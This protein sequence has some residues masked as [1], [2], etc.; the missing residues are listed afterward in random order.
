MLTK[1][2]NNTLNDFYQEID[3]SINNSEENFDIDIS[4]S[5]KSIYVKIE[6]ARSGR[7]NKNFCMYTPRAMDQGVHSFI[8][9]FN[10]H[11]Q[12]KHNGEA[13]G[14]IREAEHVREFFPNASKDFLKIVSDVNKYSEQS[15]G[16]NLVLAIKRLI[17]T[18]EY[19]SGEYRGL[20]I[21][22]IYGD[23][24]DS[25][26]IHELKVQD[27]SRGKVSIGG[28]SKEVYCSVCTSKVTKRHKHKKGN[29]YNNELCFYINNDLYLDH[30]GFVTTPADT[31]TSTEIVQDDEYDG[32]EVDIINY[33]L[34]NSVEN[35]M[36]LDDLKTKA[37][38]LDAVKKII[39][40]SFKDEADAELA[41][42]I[43]EGNLKSSRST[44]YLLATDSILNLRGPVGIHIA[45]NLLAELDD[46][47]ENKPYLKEVLQ[48]A[49]DLL[50]IEN[51]DEALKE[52]L[53][54]KKED[55]SKDKVKTPVEEV[56]SDKED[57]K[58]PT[59][60]DTSKDQKVE[61]QEDNALLKAFSDLLDTKLSKITE[62]LKVED[63]DQNAKSKTLLAE[64]S[65]LRTELNA[66]EKAINSLK[67]DYSESL[68]GQ[69]T[70]LKG[71]V[72]SDSYVSKLNTRT[73][74]Q[75]KI[76]LED[77]KEEVRAIN[78]GKE[79]DKTLEKETEA[80]VMTKVEDNF[81]PTEETTEGK[82]EDK[83]A[84]PENNT[85]EPAE[86]DNTTSVE[87][88]TK[89]DLDPQAWYQK[90]INEIGLARATK[91]F[92]IKFK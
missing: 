70:L 31:Y 82:E 73:I 62:S 76:T 77:L 79:V 33:K 61:D 85:K 43:Y 20:G 42:S 12:A 11:L 23:I 22:N 24:Y 56:T 6:A 81:K 83:Q 50:K 66:D 16:P 14:V 72:L 67:K 48:N 63:V 68:I 91:E 90:R 57:V 35:L 69:I 3:V 29:Y 2:I 9:P 39:K 51:T 40:E 34:T 49:K 1:N 25:N 59:A 78:G 65:S 87:D 71:G 36:K 54:S 52:L 38:D 17:E 53:E 30:C 7:V 27:R 47:D 55:A 41:A 86:E 84:D 8:Y 28:K 74:D 37:K 46:A 80:E 89:E 10:K 19:S 21:A 75:L 58:L 26:M 64:L 92:K 60:E 15:D 32:L 44:H 13:V 4:D 45:E 5:V 88:A 18:P